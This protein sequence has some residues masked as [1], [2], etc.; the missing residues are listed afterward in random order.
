MSLI[1]GSFGLRGGVSGHFGRF[2]AGCVRHYMSSSDRLNVESNISEGSWRLKLRGCANG[3]V[4]A[5]AGRRR[6]SC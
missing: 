3:E 5:E 6:F 1:G 4:E 2:P